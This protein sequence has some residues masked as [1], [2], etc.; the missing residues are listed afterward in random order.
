MGASTATTLRVVPVEEADLEAVAGLVNRAF[1]TY[2]HLF[3]GDRTSPADYLDEVGEG[4][5]IVLIEES[6]ALVATSM[7]T[8]AD[9]FAATEDL[10]ARANP[11]LDSHPW[12]GAFYY[13][14]AG[15][16][17]AVMNRGF[18]KKMIEQAESIAKSEGFDRL[19]LGT[20]REFGLVEYYGRVGY[21][22]IHEQEH[23]IGHW[24]FLV[25]HHYCEMLKWL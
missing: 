16:E 7:V 4:A 13:G 3:P 25:P 6:G 5:R 9:R 15:V 22:V 20:V 17:P 11:S 14:L 10:V 21:E 18:G 2:A 8:I 12:S 24:G 23:S 19:A 1:G